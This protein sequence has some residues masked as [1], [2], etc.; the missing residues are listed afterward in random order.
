MDE[1][2][3]YHRLDLVIYLVD[4]VTGAFITT[5]QVEFYRGGE[6][7]PAVC[8]ESGIYAFLN[9]EEGDFTLTVKVEGYRERQV[10]VVREALSRTAPILWI[11]MVP[12]D[13]YPQKML[14]H[15][16]AGTMKGIEDI[17]A[18]ACG[19]WQMRIREI[20]KK[21]N[22]VKLFNPHG[23]LLYPV[24]YGIINQEEKTFE[25]VTVKE[26]ISGEEIRISG[27]DI[28]NRDNNYPFGR[29]VDGYVK[30]GRY[31]LCLRRDVESYLVRWT[32]RS[33]V[34]YREWNMRGDAWKALDGKGGILWDK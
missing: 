4:T 1:R 32:V 18:V 10:K 13:D 14:I 31:I 26:Q 24:R 28:A 23:C 8:K 5:R 33:H 30:D 19:G 34:S 29:I 12:G 3:I 2:R 22:T 6:M 27:S 11:S 21:T 20:E 25:M 17:C 7:L 15:T 16:I 9:L